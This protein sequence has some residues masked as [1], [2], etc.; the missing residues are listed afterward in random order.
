[1]SKWIA[2]PLFAV[3]GLALF[4]SPL[5]AAEPTRYTMSLVPMPGSFIINGSGI[6][7]LNNQGLVAGKRRVSGHDEAI[8]WNSHTGAITPLTGMVGDS[9]AYRINNAGQVWGH[10]AGGSFIWSAAGGRTAVTFPDSTYYMKVLNDQGRLLCSRSGDTYVRAWIWEPDQSINEITIGSSHTVNALDF[11]GLGQV[12]GRYG[13]SGQNNGFLRD[14]DGTSH[15]LP[16]PALSGATSVTPYALNNA[17]VVAGRIF[18]TGETGSTA[19]AWTVQNGYTFFDLPDPFNGNGVVSMTNSGVMAINVLY[20]NYTTHVQNGAFLWTEESGLQSLSSLID[21]LS[22]GDAITSIYAINDAGQ[23]LC[24]LRP[25]SS[26]GQTQSN[27]T[28]MLLT[29]VPEPASLGLLGFG[30]VALLRRRFAATS[31]GTK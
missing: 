14:A 16:L 10:D 12:V 22:V 6:D 27:S 5:A 2:A 9:N 26:E 4:V 15:I 31:P 29:P 20:P 8:L 7:C 18:R 28:L 25:A 1:M 21:G 19:F 30:L 24:R 11:N 23:I 17:G 3:L 13:A